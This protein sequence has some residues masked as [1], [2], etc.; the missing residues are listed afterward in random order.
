MLVFH[1]YK[2]QAN[3]VQT[4]SLWARPCHQVQPDLKESLI[5]EPSRL[6]SA[7]SATFEMSA[8][9]G[10]AGHCQPSGDL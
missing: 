7:T 9:L 5:A 4:S 8:A 2:P 6:G 3:R 10:L 1:M